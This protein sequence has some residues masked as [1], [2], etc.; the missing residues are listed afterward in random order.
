M[1]LSHRWDLRVCME[2]TIVANVTEHDAG[3]QK[4]ALLLHTA[5]DVNCTAALDVKPAVVKRASTNKISSVSL[6]IMCHFASDHI[7]C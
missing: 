2:S 6:M 3:F 1:L 4:L 7:I 5:T